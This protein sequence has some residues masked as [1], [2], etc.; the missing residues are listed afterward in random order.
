MGDRLCGM[1]S[2]GSRLGVLSSCRLVLSCFV[3]FAK[4]ALGLG[5]MEGW[6]WAGLGW[7]YFIFGAF[8]WDGMG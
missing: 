5:G 7:D 8:A 6:A 1:R 2:L 3:V 4:I